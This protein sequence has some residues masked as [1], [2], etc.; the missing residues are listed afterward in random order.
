[1]DIDKNL[2]YPLKGKK[3]ILNVQR[4]YGGF[5]QTGVVKEVVRDTIQGLLQIGIDK[6]DYVFKEPAMIAGGGRSVW[7]LYGSVTDENVEA[8]LKGDDVLEEDEFVDI[9]KVEVQDGGDEGEDSA[10]GKKRSYR[11][12]STVFGIERPTRTVTR[13]IRSEE[14]RKKRSRR[15]SASKKDG[16]KGRAK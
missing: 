6:W 1:V 12:K 7:M 2:I 10:C 11:A 13:F 15:K 14:T 4:R 3:V 9:I 8:V 5:R 16:K